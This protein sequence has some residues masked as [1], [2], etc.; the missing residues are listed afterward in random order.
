[1]QDAIYEVIHAT[2]GLPSKFYSSQVGEITYFNEPI[3]LNDLKANLCYQIADAAGPEPSGVSHL[4]QMSESFP[5]NCRAIAK[6]NFE[7]APGESVESDVRMHVRGTVSV[8]TKHVTL[9]LHHLRCHSLP[10]HHKAGKHMGPGP[11]AVKC[12]ARAISGI[13]GFPWCW[14][15]PDP[16]SLEVSADEVQPSEAGFEVEE[17]SVGH[18]N[19]SIE[20]EDSVH[21]S[22][23]SN[24][25]RWSASLDADI[26]MYSSWIPGWSNPTTLKKHPTVPD[27]F[28]LPEMQHVIRWD[29]SPKLEEV[30]IEITLTVQ[31][32]YMVCAGWFSRWFRRKKYLW[33]CDIV[34]AEKYIAKKPS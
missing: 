20:R 28:C 29:R 32:G 34:E 12:E 3:D 1:M 16:G 33:K 4:S 19:G 6:H 18:V 9:T 8:N 11:T 26:A 24:D 22:Q 7:P 5:L 13:T 2:I 23:S 25:V 27:G 30:E 21:S 14:R 15:G 10:F 31:A 17:A